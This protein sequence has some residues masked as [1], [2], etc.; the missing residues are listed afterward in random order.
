MDLK[1]MIFVI[2]N[3]KGNV[4]TNFFLTLD[5]A[6]Q[7]FQ[8][9]SERTINQ[10]AKYF[11][12]LGRT[13][14]EPDWAKISMKNEKT[15]YMCYCR[16]EQHLNSFLYHKFNDENAMEVRFDYERCSKECKEKMRLYGISETGKRNKMVHYEYC[17]LEHEFREGQTLHNLNGK[18]YKVIEMLSPRNLL[19]MD[20]SN[21]NYVVGLGAGLFSRHIKGDSEEPQFGIEWE[22]GVYLSSSPSRIDFQELREKYGDQKLEKDTEELRMEQVNYFTQLY[23]LANNSYCSEEIREYL[24]EVMRAE[25]CTDKM[26]KFNQNLSAGI[27]DANSEMKVFPVTVSKDMQS[28]LSVRGVDLEDAIKVA[29]NVISMAEVH[30]EEKKVR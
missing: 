7:M 8:K 20:K 21:G 26:D 18:D 5:D 16:D 30:C 22:H 28:V 23:K 3:D 11:N 25:F 4:E 19:L 24:G 10:T 13:M 12:E 6:I 1:D 27:Y 29:T 17:H 2:E 15:V 14:T 9:S